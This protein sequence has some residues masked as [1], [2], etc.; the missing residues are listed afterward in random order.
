MALLIPPNNRPSMNKENIV[1]YFKLSSGHKMPAFGLGTWQ[2]NEGEVYE[3]VKAAIKLGYK[4]I[5]CA[6]IYQNE[7]EVGKAHKETL[8]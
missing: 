1:K 3:A 6:S 5:D 7:H 8:E 4:H 2:S